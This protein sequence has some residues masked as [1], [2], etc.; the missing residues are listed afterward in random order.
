MEINTFTMN[1]KIWRLKEPKKPHTSAQLSEQL[2]VSPFIAQLL[3]NNG[4]ESF[5][6]AKSY[7][8]PS[9]DDLHDPLLMT[10]MAKAIKRVLNAVHL[11]Q[12]ILVYGDYDV[13]GTTSVAM[14]HSFLVQLKVQSVYYIP[15]RYKEGYGV[16]S[17]GI[18]FAAEQGCKLIITLDCGIKAQERI[19]QANELGIDVII[20]DH[21]KPGATL[22]KAYAVLDPQRSD[23]SYPC[24]A[25]SGC[26]VG[27]KLIQGIVEDQGMDPELLFQYLDLVTISIGADIV[28]MIGEN[29]V[30]ATFGLKGI[31]AY[32]RPGIA[33]LF[34]SAKFTKKSITISDLVFIIAPR[35]NA[36]GR[37][38]HATTAVELLISETRE[39]AD[40]ISAIIE[41]YNSDRKEK[42]KE[43][44][45]AAIQTMSIEPW[46]SSSWSTVVQGKGWHKGVI[47]IV[48]SRLIETYYKPTIVFTENKGVLV[49]SARSIN[50][51][52]IHAALEMCSDLLEQFG[53]HAMAAGMTMKLAN[54]EAFRE[55]FD[56]VVRSLISEEMLIPVIEVD[57][58]L[59]FNDIT[60]GSYKILRQFA[61]FGPENM[62]PIFLAKN[63]VDNSGSRAVGDDR[64]HLK[65]DVKQEHGGQVMQGI[66]FKMGKHLSW[67]KTNTPI[68]LVFTLEE[69]EWRERVSLQLQVEDIKK[70]AGHTT[71]SQSTSEISQT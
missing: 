54:F 30:L 65:L 27:F 22:P 41:E 15:D 51:L 59:N 67:L 56:L 14:M 40:R 47:G 53:G 68:D 71:F 70:S 16:S 17:D 24:K 25:L 20:C 39:D 52:D 45:V 32:Q 36:A 50:G 21:H 44:T 33:S 1:E 38:K 55:K 66:A 61:P 8:R 5:E 28:P 60:T 63:C 35:I 7:F 11:D 26:G 3:V 37:I 10:D 2:G 31:H 18:L 19:D 69:N 46:Y 62:K 6:A 42:D 57:Q 34:A 48:A 23:C 58:E 49:G 64:S 4:I 43:T 29:R 13:D 9:L 12:K